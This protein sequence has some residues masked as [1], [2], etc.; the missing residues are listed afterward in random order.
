M[1]AAQGLESRE[2]GARLFVS[3]RTVDSHLHRIYA[4]LRVHGRGELAEALGIEL[5]LM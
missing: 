3:A 2:I 5:A 1:R 4:K